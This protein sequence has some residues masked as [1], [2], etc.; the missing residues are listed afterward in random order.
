MRVTNWKL[1]NRAVLLNRQGN[2]EEALKLL[3]QA[4]EFDSPDSE[5]DVEYHDYGLNSYTDA[6]DVR[7][8]NAKFHKV[9]ESV[10]LIVHQG[11]YPYRVDYVNAIG[12]KNDNGGKHVAHV[13]TPT[14]FKGEVILATGYQG[15]P[16]S[17]DQ[18]ISHSIGQEIV[19]NGKFSLPNLG[20]LAI[21]LKENGERVS[22]V[23]GNLGLP[24][25]H[26]FSY[27]IYFV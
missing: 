26:H 22:E 27:A 15:N 19:I 18:E 3:E 9:D 14:S 2:E 17:F 1:I 6:Y 8:E 20:P 21:Y 4:I 12:D 5:P 11:P 7:G 16:D 23:V 10:H 13:Y 24:D 25:G